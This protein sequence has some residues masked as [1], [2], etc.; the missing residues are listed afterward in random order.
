MMRDLAFLQKPKKIRDHLLSAPSSVGIGTI[1]GESTRE[2]NADF[3]SRYK[4]RHVPL[5]GGGRRAR[6]VTPDLRYY[7]EGER[8]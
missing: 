6:Y 3:F 8:E 1:R 7:W 4:R 2:E 5:W